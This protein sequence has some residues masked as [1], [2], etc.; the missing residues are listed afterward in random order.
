[1]SSSSTDDRIHD[2]LDK[3]DEAIKNKQLQ[4]AAEVL[5]E[6]SH[7]DPNNAQVK[8]RWTTL[9]K[10]DA[11]GDVLELLKTY[12]G[13]QGAEDGQK[14]LQALKTKPLSANDAVQAIE[15]LLRIRSSPDLLDSLTGTLL[16]RNVEA[17]K[18]VATKLSENA[19]EL[20]ELLFERGEDSFLAL[21]SIPGET[22]IW[23]SQNDQE[24]AQRDIFRLC[25][26]TL[27]EAGADHLERVMRC[28]SRLLTVA[29]DNVGDIIDEDVL[30]AI[31]SSLDIR[32]AAPLRHQAM[33]ATSKLLEATKQRGEELF[34]QFIMGRASKQTN[35]DLIV[36]FSAAAAVFPVIPA[37]AA[38]LFLTDGFVQQLVPNLERNSEDGA[39]GKRYTVLHNTTF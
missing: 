30:D 39:A 20:F 33:L 36:V 7:L 8:E 29:P 23:Q 6:A 18:F 34:S 13:S 5:R 35:D 38:R 17:R 9:H 27:I 21:A 22:S 15:L 31:L 37:V 1:M 11:G 2:L 24:T 14:A 4:K 32:L 19:T 3:A 26:A 10:L 16:L 28:I 25:V 12:L